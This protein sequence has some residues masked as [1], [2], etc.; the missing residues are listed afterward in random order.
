MGVPSACTSIQSPYAP[1]YKFFSGHI[2]VKVTFSAITGQFPNLSEYPHWKFFS[3]SSQVQLVYVRRVCSID[4]QGWRQME[5]LTSSKSP[6]RVSLS[7]KVQ[8]AEGKVREKEEFYGLGQEVPDINSTCICSISLLANPLHGWE[9]ESGW[10]YGR[11][12]KESD[13]WLG[14]FGA[15][16]VAQTVKNLP[17]IQ[18][19]W[20]PSLG[21][22][23][24]LEKE[25]AT[26]SSILAWEIPWTEKPGEL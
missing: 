26:H 14:T 25:M 6:S 7:G 8:S 19:T 2:L 15:S 22:E 20:V 4:S 1:Q 18:E 23:D 13:G 24:P 16:L 10:V 17:A 21:Q 9:M 3:H 11:K 5:G 12:E